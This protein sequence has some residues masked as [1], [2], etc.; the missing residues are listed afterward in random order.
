MR[1]RAYA[2]SRAR[3]GAVATGRFAFLEF[4]T[5]AGALNCQRNFNG[6]A[7]DKKH[8]VVAYMY[9]ELKS[10]EAAPEPSTIELRPR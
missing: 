4:T 5:R 9:R 3:C 7:L 1:A 6:W 10:C 2:V 8:T